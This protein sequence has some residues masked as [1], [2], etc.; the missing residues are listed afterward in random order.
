MAPLTLSVLVVA[1]DSAVIAYCLYFPVPIIFLCY[2]FFIV[3]N[4]INGI[5]II[6]WRF[7]KEPA[8]CLR[9]YMYVF[10]CN[11]SAPPK[12]WPPNADDTTTCMWQSPCLSVVS[13]EDVPSVYFMEKSWT[14]SVN[15]CCSNYVDARELVK[16]WHYPVNGKA[17]MHR[18]KNASKWD[19]E[20][21]ESLRCSTFF[22]NKT[23]SDGC[24]LEYYKSI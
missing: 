3:L 10:F 23:A 9:S 18:S 5:W 4:K 12:I 7:W 14:R 6:V 21:A 16:L 13:H 2:I 22:Y 24:G 19:Y 15:S 1:A 17:E 20:P 11:C 8:F